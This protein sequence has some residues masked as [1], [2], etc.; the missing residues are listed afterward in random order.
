MRRLRFAASMLV[1]PGMGQAAG[2]AVK[3]RLYES[4]E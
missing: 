2:A 3:R 4:S 1:M